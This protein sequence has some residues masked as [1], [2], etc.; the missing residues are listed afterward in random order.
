MALLDRFKKKTGL[1][2]SKVAGRQEEKS[3]EEKPQ[4]KERAL[5][6]R[7]KIG[8]KRPGENIVKQIPQA[9]RLIREPQI[10][11]KATFLTSQNKYVFKV[12]PQANKVEVKKTVEA[13]YGVKVV[14]VHLIHMP[15]KK[16]RLGRIQGWRGGLKKGFKKVIVTLASGE[17][18]ELL[19]K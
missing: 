3:R 10:T 4:L 17:K 8:E 16:R 11:E 6:N 13:L 9:Y 12:S 19:P 1:I 7:E 14:K 18:I 15:A 2:K 5:D